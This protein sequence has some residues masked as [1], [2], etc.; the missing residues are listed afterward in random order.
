M[1]IEELDLKKL[2]LITNYEEIKNL[3]KPVF[4]GNGM[5]DYMYNNYFFFKIDNNRFFEIKKYSSF[6][7]VKTIWYDDE[8]EAPKKTLNNFILHQSWDFKDFNNKGK[9]FYTLFQSYSESPY[10]FSLNIFDI[11]S[12]YGRV[13]DNYKY[14]QN[15]NVKL[16]CLN[17]EWETP[18]QLHEKENIDTDLINDLISILN[19]NNSKMQERL[20]KYYN[21]YNNQISVKGYWA[22]R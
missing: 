13:Y 5:I 14:Y 21:R 19:F 11:N 4:S 16:D 12:S 8:K 10:L 3:I 15:L 1:K 9:N 6:S 7:I 17:Y 22:N 20:K 18:Y 2:K